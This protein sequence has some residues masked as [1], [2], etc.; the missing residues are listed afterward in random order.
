M[1]KYL[2]SVADVDDERV[3][4]RLHGDPSAVL[5]H[6]QPSHFALAQNGEKVG[7]CVRSQSQ[8]ERRKRTWGVV[9]H[10]RYTI[11]GRAVERRG[12]SVNR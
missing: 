6:L 2:K 8:S 5:A 10:T 7:I 11:A 1:F 9:V 3:W 4:L 12:E